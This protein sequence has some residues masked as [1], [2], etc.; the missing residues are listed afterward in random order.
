LPSY[1]WSAAWEEAAATNPPERLVVPTLQIDHPALSL[2]IYVA[3]NVNADIELP[4]VFGGGLVLHKAIPFWA[5]DPEFSQGRVPE[6]RVT[7]DN[8][9]REL[10]PA[11]YEVSLTRG[12]LMITFRQYITDDLTEP[13]YGPVVFKL[14]N[15]GVA[16]NAVTGLAQLEN[17]AQ[18]KL[19]RRVHTIQSHP[20]LL[21]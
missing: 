9:A 8:V 16:G 11:L 14:R 13:V 20:G 7:I 15:I 17:Y 12:N 21:P 5:D 4:L 6:T 3:T 19:P 10:S 18:M 2:P 1:P